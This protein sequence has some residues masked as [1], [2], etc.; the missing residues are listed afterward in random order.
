MQ[1]CIGWGKMLKQKFRRGN[2]V[3]IKKGAC[4][5]N[6]KQGCNAIILGSYDDFF[7]GGDIFQ[8]SV[9]FE[10]GEPCSW[11]RDRQLILVENGG[12]QL[13]E[14]IKESRIRREAEHILVTEDINH[15]YEGGIVKLLRF[16]GF[17]YSRSNNYFELWKE[18]LPIFQK[19]KTSS[20][21][22][23]LKSEYPEYDIEGVWNAF[24]KSGGANK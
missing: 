12:E 3:H 24:H 18:V 16:I 2:L 17:D 1:W 14:Q 5:F 13:I 4:Q 23:I 6:F 15:L 7:G 10:D 9:M 21:P 19:I 8:Y 22:E 11:Y 20:S